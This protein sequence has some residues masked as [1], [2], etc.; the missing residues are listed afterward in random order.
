MT[1]HPG[2]GLARGVE[3]LH[4]DDVIVTLDAD[5]THN[6]FLIQRM[7][8]QIAEGSD[9][10]IASRYQPGARVLGLSFFRVLT[11]IGAGFLFRVGVGLEG[12]KDYTCGF[13]V[14]RVDVL[15]KTLTHYGDRFILQKGFGCMAE[16][17]IKTA[18][19]STVISEVPM[20]LRY[21]FKRGVS[22]MKVMSTV[23][24]TCRMILDYRLG[25]GFR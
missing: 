7:L 22:K 14:Y 4:D 16:I 5:N 8:G 21:D 13:R 6:P 15:K 19:F 24:Q 10:V 23:L 3:G 11:S 12:V 25:R 18:Q 1:P 20:I 17:L 2:K 9:I